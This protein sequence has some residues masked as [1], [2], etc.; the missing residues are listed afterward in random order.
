MSSAISSVERLRIRPCRGYPGHQCQ[1]IVRHPRLRCES[2]APIHKKMAQSALEQARE[3]AGLCRS[4]T[5][6][7]K[8][9]AGIYCAPCR[10]RNNLK[11][12]D[13]Y[14]KRVGRDV[15]PRTCSGCGVA[16]H[17]VRTCPKERA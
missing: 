7:G 3:E 15:V 12:R 5:C 17:N 6:G 4:K 9:E 2:C 16:G 11:E 14:A 13:L 1:I 10:E 8:A